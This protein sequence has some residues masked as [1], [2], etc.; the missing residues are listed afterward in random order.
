MITVGYSV[1]GL[2]AEDENSGPHRRGIW[3]SVI[4][5][6]TV[7]SGHRLASSG[8]DILLDGV[9]G[10]PYNLVAEQPMD[11]NRTLV[12]EFATWPSADQ[13]LH[14]IAASRPDPLFQSGRMREH[15]DIRWP[16]PDLAR[17][18]RVL[19]G[20]TQSAG[21]RDLSQ[22]HGIL[23]HGGAISSAGALVAALRHTLET[24]DRWGGIAVT[25]G[26]GAADNRGDWR[27]AFNAPQVLDETTRLQAAGI[28]VLSGIG[29]ESDVTALDRLADYSWPTPSTLAVTLGRLA[30]YRERAGAE[31]ED[32][33]ERS[34]YDLGREVRQEFDDAW[35]RLRPKSKQLLPRPPWGSES[36]RFKCAGRF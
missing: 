16:L 36:S 13:R 31:Q 30:R 23:R 3:E 24:G 12:Q 18:I 26:G 11:Q 8:F 6:G 1:S 2:R 17:P 25:R 33:L 19:T 15:W 28:V 9:D 29:H 21:W 7:R 10:D 5:H 4:V 27:D 22:V 20:S 34:V 14:V 32:G 35:A